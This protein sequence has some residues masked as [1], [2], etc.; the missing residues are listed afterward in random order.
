MAISWLGPAGCRP[1]GTSP[2]AR[3]DQEHAGTG[4][5]APPVTQ[6]SPS[7]DSTPEV[8][9]AG[10]PTSSTPTNADAHATRS[11]IARLWI[12]YGAAKGDP[13]RLEALDEMLQQYLDEHPDDPEALLLRADIRLEQDRFDEALAAAERC[14]EV[15]P[16]TAGCWLTVGVLAETRGSV[17]HAIEAYRRYLEL[18][19]DGRYAPDARKAVERLEA[20]RRFRG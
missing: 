4:D 3:P 18:A 20:D 11:T 2:T 8:V 19:P 6:A 1:N 17:E 7:D 16:E 15:S 14:L 9:G 10:E 12:A 13:A 5:P